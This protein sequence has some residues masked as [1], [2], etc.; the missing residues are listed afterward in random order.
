M[1]LCIKQP[2]E[3]YEKNNERNERVGRTSVGHTGVLLPESL[4]KQP[5]E[6][7]KEL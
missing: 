2:P 3:K 5:P 7:L 6:T 1:V 4:I